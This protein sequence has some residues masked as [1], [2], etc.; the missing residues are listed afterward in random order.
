[1]T[2][3]EVGVVFGVA[4]ASFCVCGA[5]SQTL[6][7]REYARRRGWLDAMTPGA[8]L[9]SRRSMGWGLLLAAGWV[10]VALP[11]VLLL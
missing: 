7:Q 1:M 4:F 5:V 10:L 9:P 11:V 2:N 6:R 3:A 8:V